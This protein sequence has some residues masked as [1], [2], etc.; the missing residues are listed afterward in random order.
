MFLGQYQNS[1]DA[2]GRTIIPAKFR[3]ELGSNFVLTKGLENCLF[4]YPMSQW[5]S[6]REKLNNLPL[7]SKESRAFVRRFFA[8]AVECELDKQGR[9]N[10]PP[11]LREHA[12]LDKELVTIGVNERIEIWSK[13]NWD[14][15]SEGIDDEYEEILQE[16]SGLGI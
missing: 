11:V 15:Y 7:T 6:F 5:E 12:E 13:V 14:K 2:K 10:I 1:I 9:V 8:G 3:D 4:I 16:I